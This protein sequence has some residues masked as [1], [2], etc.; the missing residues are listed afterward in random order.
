MS[1]DMKGIM[2]KLVLYSILG[3]FVVTHSGQPVM[4]PFVLLE[5]C[6]EWANRISH[7]HYNVSSVC[8]HH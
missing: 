8:Q 1:I 6:Q 2:S 5:V 4:G 7:R 3:W